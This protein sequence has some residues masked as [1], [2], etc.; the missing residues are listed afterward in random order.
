MK[1]RFILAQGHYRDSQHQRLYFTPDIKGVS[2]AQHMSHSIIRLA[3]YLAVVCG[4]SLRHIA[5]I[6][7]ALFL[8][9]I[10]K[11]SIKR[12]IDDIGTNLPSQEEMLQQL[13]AITPATECHIDGYYPLGTDH[14]VMVVRDEHD[15]ILM[16]HEAASENGADAR[17]FLQRLKDHGLRV[18]AAFSDYSQSFTEAI[19]AVYPHA[20]LQADHF[21][22][23]KNL[24]G[25]LKKALLSSRRKIQ[26]N[27]EAKHD[28]DGLELAKTLWKLR[29]SL[30]KKPSNLSAEEQQAIAELEKV[31]EGFVHR[32]RS[33]IRQLVHIF[34]H[35]HSEA[36]ANIRLKQLRQDIRA[37]DDDHLEKI[38]TF[39]DDHWEQALRYLRKKGMGTHRRGSNSE[40]GMRLL[41]RL[42]KSHDGI[43]SAA[44]RQHYIQIY[45]AVKYLSLDIAQ[46]IEQGPQYPF[47]FVFSSY[48]FMPIPPLTIMRRYGGIDMNKTYIVRL[49][50]DERQELV[51]LT[52][53]G[54]A[55][56]YKIKHAH[57]LLHVDAN[58]PNW[59]DDACG[60]RLALSWQY[61]SQCPSTLCRTRARGRFG[62]Q[63]AGHTL[64]SAP[65]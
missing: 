43:R 22:T 54:K 20:R 21:H 33:I 46:F 12:W 3:C 9:P 62:P 59:S 55:A 51:Q 52:R 13:L 63:K 34:D 6:F 10:T 23:V 24:W 44:T 4:V 11:S 42:E 14:C 53:S 5:V 36:Q 58:G 15:R 30:L 50:D 7:S 18:T 35:S 37:V 29:W 26:A 56:A 1:Y 60:H 38:L 19:K 17:Q 31:D 48:R 28:Q 64:A 41:R 49:T 27:G 8:I 2:T 45:Q 61:G 65:P 57:I 32:F 25:H 16:T 39:F 47:I 40:S